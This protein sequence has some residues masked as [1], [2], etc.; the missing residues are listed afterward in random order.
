MKLI[1]L[2][3]GSAE[4]QAYK[5]AHFDASDAP[6]MLGI[7]PYKTRD[8]L[9]REK[10]TGLVPEIDEAK[11]KLID[12]IQR[13][14]RLARH[15]TEWDF[16]I[17]LPPRLGVLEGT[18]LSASFDGLPMDGK[19]VWEH[20]KLNDTLRSLKLGSLKYRDDLPEHYCAQMEQQ[21]LVSGASVVDFVA[22]SWDDD[23]KVIAYYTWFYRSDP[24]L[25]QRIID[26]WAQF[27]RDLAAARVAAH[28]QQERER[29]EAERERIRAEEAARLERENQ[30]SP[31][32]ENVA[33]L[34]YETHKVR[35]VT[36]AHAEGQPKNDAIIKLGDINAAIAP[37]SI[38]ADGLA[39]L[40][41]VHVATDKAA[42]LYRAA[43]FPRIRQMLVEHLAVTQL[44]PIDRQHR[45]VE[46]TRAA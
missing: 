21:L 15:I 7:S 28:E 12:E 33:T 2:K 6:A 31:V 11:Q 4:W 42:R 23:D 17:S 18:K 10:A 44:A 5:L 43:D 8:E 40:G 13:F 25:R 34:P 3:Y 36:L 45:S 14:K 16:Y 46:V 22:S 24:D 39:Q 35:E 27:E 26:G 38:S 29:M 32:K 20:K 41:C 9:L 1:Y 37:L 19:F 30:P